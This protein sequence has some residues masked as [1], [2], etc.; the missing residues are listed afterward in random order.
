MAVDLTRR[1]FFDLELPVVE[2]EVKAVPR[3]DTEIIGSPQT[4]CLLPVHQNA[5][6]KFLQNRDE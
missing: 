3:P 6:T 4:G 2:D 1:W 5:W